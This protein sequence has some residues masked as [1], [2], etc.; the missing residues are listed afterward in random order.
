MKVP[1]TDQ[2]Q[3]L[4]TN[5]NSFFLTNIFESIYNNDRADQNIS[6]F[7]DRINSI[8]LAFGYSY[9]ASSDLSSIK[10]TVQKLK[11]DLE[12]DRYISPS[13]ILQMEKIINWCD[14]LANPSQP[15]RNSLKS[16]M[17]INLRL[18]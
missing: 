15:D 6:K 17:P 5:L 14:E 4:K 12:K 7:A 1:T 18:M 11:S 3:I 2:M 16:D 10:T 8:S 13:H 9:K